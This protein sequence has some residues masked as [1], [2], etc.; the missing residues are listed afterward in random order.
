MNKLETFIVLL[1]VFAAGMVSTTLLPVNAAW[2]KFVV[3]HN[4]DGHLE[5][6]RFHHGQV[7]HTWQSGQGD[8]GWTAW[9]EL[10]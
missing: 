7:L 3:E 6:L 1:V 5:I 2:D 10:R 4:K 9:E 8:T